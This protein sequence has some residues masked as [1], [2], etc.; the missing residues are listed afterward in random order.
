MDRTAPFKA[1]LMRLIGIFKKMWRALLWILSEAWYLPLLNIFSILI[2]CLIG[3]GVFHFIGKGSIDDLDAK[4]I[5][6]NLL[7]VNGVFSAILITYL[8]SRITWFMD[9][10]LEIMKEAVSLSQKVTEFRRILHI[11]TSYY[12]LWY[13]DNAAKNLVDHGKYKNIDFYD[14]RK[15]MSSEYI[16]HN[17]KLIDDFFNDPNFKE[18]HSTLYLAM[19]SLIRDRNNPSYE[20]HEELYSDFELNGI[21]N[22]DIVERWLDCEI[23]GTIYF[24]MDKDTKY[25]NYSNLGK[26]DTEFIQ[27]A[28]ARINIKYKGNNLSN[29]LFKDLSS[30]FSEYYLRELHFKLKELKKGVNGLNL[31][32]IIL[33][34][35]SLLF[36]I[37]I[38]FSLL[39]IP[40]KDIWYA[41]S[42]SILAAINTG[43]IS[44]FILRFPVLINRE[45]KWI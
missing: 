3:A 16:P 11:L 19:T 31:L 9:R 44:Y 4:S 29:E 32:I 45:L 27:A 41:Y 25:I 23:F 13:D 35:V 8:F 40:S 12:K 42:V 17:K 20:F 38:P 39:L 21:Y 10:K 26:K 22:L 33:T 36:G 30:E 18:G 6:T 28:V 43:L 7:T 5:L 37:L 24:W 2:C 14:Y 15:S 34:T 1:D